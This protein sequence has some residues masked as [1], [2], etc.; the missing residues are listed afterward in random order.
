M[1]TQKVL[2]DRLI[3]APQN[4]TDIRPGEKPS[5][6]IKRIKREQKR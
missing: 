4:N 6:W 1:T 3:R 5:A 2:D